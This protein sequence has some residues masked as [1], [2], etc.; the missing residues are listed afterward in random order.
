MFVFFCFILTSFVFRSPEYIKFV[1]PAVRRQLAIQSRGRVVLER[2]SELD[3]DSVGTTKTKRKRLCSEISIET[4]DL[5]R[6][7]ANDEEEEKGE[8]LSWADQLKS[9]FLHF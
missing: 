7:I 9:V 3:E 1:P 2:G 8:K 6:P 5:L 4:K